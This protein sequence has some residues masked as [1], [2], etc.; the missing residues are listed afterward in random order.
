[1][2]GRPPSTTIIAITDRSKGPRG[3]SAFIVEK[4]TRDFG[5]GKKESKMGIRASATGELIFNQC[6]IPKDRLSPKKGWGFIVAMKTFD[7]V[8]SR[9][10]FPGGWSGPGGFG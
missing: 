9:H 7:Y 5:F 2:P 6:R 3:A 10:R 1:M 4:M 8:A